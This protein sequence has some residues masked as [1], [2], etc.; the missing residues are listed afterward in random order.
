MKFSRFYTFAISEHYINE[1]FEEKNTFNITF[2]MSATYVTGDDI[3][4][5]SVVMTKKILL[6]IRLVLS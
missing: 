2:Y 5:I 6:I 3:L 4:V 1:K